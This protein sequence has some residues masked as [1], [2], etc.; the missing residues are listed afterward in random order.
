MHYFHEVLTGLGLSEDQATFAMRMLSL[1]VLFVA[2]Y[3]VH[4]L[5]KL[6][7]IRIFTG[8]AKKTK[9]L[10]DDLMVENRVLSRVAQIAPVIL[11]SILAPI[12]FEGDS[13]WTGLV[14]K[15]VILYL[16][17]VVV[18]IVDSVLNLILNVYQKHPL[19]KQFPIKGLVQAV[20]LIAILF[21]IIMMIAEIIGESPVVL[22]SGLGAMTAV[23]LLVFRDAILGFVAG[24]QLSANNMVSPGDWIEMPK[25]GAD[26]DVIDVTLTTVKVQNWDKTITSIPAYALVQDAFK[27]WKGMSE[28]GGRR[29]KRALY[30]DIQSIGFLTEDVTETFRGYR[31]LKRYLEEKTEEIATH[32]RM[33]RDS[34]NLKVDGRALT[35]IGTF[36]AYCISY[37]RNHPKVRQD[38]TLLV[39]QLEPTPHGLPIQ[40]YCF[41]ND[42]VWANYESIQSDIFDH[43]FAVL[44]EFDLRAFQEPSGYDFRALAGERR[45]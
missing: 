25:Y 33:I 4:Q 13:Q 39:R 23:L 8:W 41:T 31:F 21:A 2:A 9:T 11:V 14:D 32:N 12:L 26:G 6:I 17:V 1:V 36:R 40:I 28:T 38:L 16:I 35:N 15:A 20:K 43:L 5:T 44:P 10:W 19:A 24:I 18:L 45:T 27:N 30:I 37:L 29:I 7:V 34:V 22:L 42:I 3:L